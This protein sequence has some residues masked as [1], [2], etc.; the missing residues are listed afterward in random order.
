M[1]HKKQRSKVPRDWAVAIE[2]LGIDAGKRDPAPR[3]VMLEVRRYR[4][5]AEDNVGA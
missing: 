4:R 5:T 2:G 3:R 1:K